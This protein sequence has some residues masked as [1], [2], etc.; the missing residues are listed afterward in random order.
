MEHRTR[1]HMFEHMH[2]GQSVQAEDVALL[3]VLVDLHQCQL[4][5][6]LCLRIFTRSCLHAGGLHWCTAD[7]RARQCQQQR[8]QDAALHD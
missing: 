5:N 3:P 8:Q 7:V 4:C 6:S 2:V 1:T